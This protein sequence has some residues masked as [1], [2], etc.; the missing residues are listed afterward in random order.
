MKAENHY[1]FYTWVFADLERVTQVKAWEK[2]APAPTKCTTTVRIAA[3]AIF[4]SKVIEKIVLCRLFAYLNSHDLLCP[5]QSAY[6]PRHSTETALFKMT[7]DILLVSGG[8]SVLNLLGLSSAFSTT[9]HH[10][11][12]LPQTSISLWRFWHRSFVV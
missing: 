5:S 8:A 9:D 7:N 3:A 2:T 10:N 4:L 6:R 1:T 11:Y 12:S